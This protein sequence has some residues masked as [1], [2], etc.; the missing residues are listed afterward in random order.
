MSRQQSSFTNPTTWA[1]LA[2]V[3]FAGSQL[4]VLWTHQTNR[5][6]ET[7]H[8]DLAAWAQTLVV[9]LLLWPRLH[10]WY[11]LVPAGIAL[12]AGP[13]HR[14]LYVQVLGLIFLSYL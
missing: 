2:L 11:A 8:D 10:T 3:L 7:I 9:F 1:V 13:H 6:S 4:S 5:V 14:R 12:A